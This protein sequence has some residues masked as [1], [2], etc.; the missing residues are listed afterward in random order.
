MRAFS[1]L[2][3]VA[4][5][6]AVPAA[7][8]AKLALPA[9]QAPM[10]DSAELLLKKALDDI[11][12]QQFD[13]ALGH[14]D[15]LLRAQPNFRLAHLIKGDLLLAKVKPL[16]AMGGVGNSERLVDL[17]EEAVARLRALRERPSPDRVPKYLLQLRTDDKY[18]IVVD[19]SRSRLYFYRNEDG[20]PKL[21]TDYYVSSGKNGAQKTREGDM[22]TPIGV[23]YVTSSLPRAKL[24]DFYGSGAYPISYP[25]EWDRRMGRNGHGIWLHGTPSN[26]YSRAPRASDGCVVLS[27]SDLESL[28]P[29]LQIGLTPVII[30]EGV[31]WAPPEAVRQERKQFLAE[32]DAWRADWESRDTAR[33][34]SHYSG[35]FSSAN[36]NFD[37]WRAHKGKVNAAKS[38]IK[39]QLSEVSVFRD[40]GDKEMV[41]VSFEQHYQSNNLSNVMKK[42]QYWRNEAG[43][44]KIV[45]EGS[46]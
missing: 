37:S 30:S 8:T 18:A 5:V 17:R 32:L 28:A 13:T 20:T 31:E 35:K 27:N 1:A 22:K 11:G 16:S 46:A 6:L 21:V 7:T 14:I 25:N 33:Y 3:G 41:V 45:Y 12:R 38:W 40:P 15:D 39:V 4:L 42:R 9:A 19:T 34:M 24:P 26:T 43:R 36:E 23:Y 44:W 2:L 10:R 29:D